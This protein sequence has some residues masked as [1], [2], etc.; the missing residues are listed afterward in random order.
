METSNSG[1]TGDRDYRIVPGANEDDIL[2]IAGNNRALRISKDLGR[3]LT[4]HGIAG[5][6]AAERAD[7]DALVAA[8]II[9]AD[10]TARTRAASFLDGA[11]LAININLTAFCNLGCSYCFADGGDY[12]RIKGRMEADMVGEILRLCTGARDAEPDGALRVFRRRA[13][14]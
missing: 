3:R 6:T 14:A 7:W 8:G 10:N 9:S 13:T 4:A 2:F 11:N 12:G 1:W 5:L